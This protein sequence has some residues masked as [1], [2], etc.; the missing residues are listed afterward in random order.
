MSVPYHIFAKLG[1]EAESPKYFEFSNYLAPQHPPEPQCAHQ[2]AQPPP[3]F[4]PHP[5]ARP[6]SPAAPEPRTHCGHAPSR[7]ARCCR[8]IRASYALHTRCTR[9]AY[10]LHTRAVHAAYALPRSR[11]PWPNCGMA[12]LSR[13]PVG[14]TRRATMATTLRASCAFAAP[15]CRIATTRF[16]SPC[17]PPVLRARRW[18]RV[19]PTA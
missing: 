3:I 17:F 2:A 4:A 8:R 14:S 15:L 1:G 13:T 11:L 9:A 18:R 7:D 12:R 19:V 5:S 16:V 6:L 10:A